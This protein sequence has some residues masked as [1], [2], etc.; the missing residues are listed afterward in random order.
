[1]V[2][3]LVQICMIKAP[4]RELTGGSGVR[5]GDKSVEVEF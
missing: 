2:G 1:M 5:Q 4:K 3:R